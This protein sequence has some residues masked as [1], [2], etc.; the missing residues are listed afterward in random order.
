MLPAFSLSLHMANFQRRGFRTDRPAAREQLEAVAVSFLTGYNLA[1][2][3]RD[4]AD[5]HGL[6]A[7]VAE[8]QRGFAYEGAGMQLAIGDLFRPGRFRRPEQLAT[9][10]GAGFSHLVHVGAGWP[11]APTRRA[12]CLRL[13]ATPLL[14][15]LAV[16]G[17]G[18]GA[19]FFGGEPA[20]RRICRAGSGPKRRVR[21][22]GAGRALWFQQ[23]ADV[24]AV[25][26]VIAGQPAVAAAD[27]WAG[28]GLACGYA[29]ATDT[30]GRQ[31][32]IEHSGRYLANVRQGVLFAT[33]ARARSGWVPE[34]TEAACRELLGL[35]AGQAARWT[36]EESADLDRRLDVQA[37]QLWRHRLTVRAGGAGSAERA[38]SLSRVG[39]SGPSGQ[40]QP[41]TGAATAH[42]R[43]VLASAPAE[44]QP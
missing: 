25:A 43:Y 15:W 27:L 28:V 9:G 21:I 32:L 8:P 37:Y 6:L 5:L 35:S 4:L 17:A 18:F 3:A 36:D 33:A 16:D 39:S 12:Y 41:P 2:R 24:P 42:S 30:A 38:G 40:P 22:A 13:P 1:A 11:L 31:A 10:P 34:H 26:R 7:E 44:D 19:A 14:R 20:L 29:G 23:A